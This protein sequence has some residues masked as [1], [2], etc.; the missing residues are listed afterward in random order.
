VVAGQRHEAAFLRPMP[1]GTAERVGAIDGAVG[2]EGFGAGAE[3]TPEQPKRRIDAGEDL[4]VLDVRNP[5]EHRVCRIP[6]AALV[7]LPDLPARLAEVP[8]GRE[9]I[10][11]CTGGA[12]SAEA[13]DLLKVDGYKHPVNLSGGILAWAERVDPGMARY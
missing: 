12:R 6:G 11:H 13:I 1:D 9:V 2:D 3:I 10:V 5:H 8:R 4:F 7:P